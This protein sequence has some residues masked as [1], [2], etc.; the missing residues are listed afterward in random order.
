[1]SWDNSP[2]TEA[3]VK[4]HLNSTV[5]ENY[6]VTKLFF[7]AHQKFGILNFWFSQDSQLVINL[8][9][10]K[11]RRRVCTHLQRHLCCQS[12][13]RKIVNK[14]TA[15]SSGHSTNWLQYVILTVSIKEN[16]IMISVGVNM[17]LSHTHTHLYL[18]YVKQKNIDLILS[19]HR[20][21]NI[22]CFH[23]QCNNN[24]L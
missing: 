17:S 7:S 19:V 2:S 20:I 14:E 4:K 8:P 16:D 5:A 11:R 24:A 1:M 3:T 6:T 10:T 12:M 9:N 15:N 23:V 21:Y 22:K 13:Y 18:T